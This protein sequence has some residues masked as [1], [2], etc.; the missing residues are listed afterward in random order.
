MEGLLGGC[1]RGHMYVFGGLDRS[2]DKMPGMKLHAVAVACFLLAAV[3]AA[4]DRPSR[5]A[6]EKCAWQKLSS[7]SLG[8]EA[9]VQ[10]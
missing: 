2:H 6:F 9:W 5:P 4:A 3:A 1:A 7:S 10:R 8:L